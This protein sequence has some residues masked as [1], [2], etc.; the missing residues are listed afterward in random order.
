MAAKFVFPR[1]DEIREIGEFVF[2]EDGH[3]Y[4]FTLV[5]KAGN[6][7]NHFI[8]GDYQGLEDDIRDLHDKYDK[9]VILV[10]FNKSTMD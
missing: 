5:L 7:Q 1:K 6:I 8:R 9:L 10:S 3:R 4:G 2:D